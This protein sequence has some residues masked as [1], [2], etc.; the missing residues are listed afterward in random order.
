[1]LCAAM[2]PVPAALADV[3]ANSHVQGNQARKAFTFIR[4]SL[5]IRLPSP[6]LRSRLVRARL[7]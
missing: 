3:L 1:M 4:S 6:A 5:S 7:Y 2:D